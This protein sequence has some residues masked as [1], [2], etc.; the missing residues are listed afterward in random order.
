MP[1]WSPAFPPTATNNKSLGALRPSRRPEILSR[2]GRAWVVVALVAV[3]FLATSLLRTINVPW[4]EEDN[5][6]GA[7][8]AQAAANNLR[9]GLAVTAGV[10]A[11]FHVGPLPI[12]PDAYYVHHP[13]L[14]PLLVTASVAILGEKEWAVKLVPILCSIVSAIL[15][16]FLVEEAMGKRPAAF[17]VAFFVT[18]PMEL[19]YGDLVDFEPCLVT[20]MLAALLCLRHW[21]V[22]RNARWASLAALCCVGALWT[23]WPGY[24]FTAAV[25]TRLLLK[26]DKPSRRLAALLAVLALC[27]GILFLLQIRH[28]NPEGWRDLRTAISM[29]LGNGTQPG[30]SVNGPGA[31]I[32][33]GFWEWLRRIFQALDQNYLRVTWLFVLAGAVHL[34]RHRKSPRPKWIAWTALLMAVAG[35]PY[36]VILRNWSFVHDFASFFVMGSIAILG[37]MGI[38]AAWQWVEGWAGSPRIAA[39]ATA[40]LLP[41]LAW[42]GFRRAEEQRSPFLIL[43]GSVREPAHLIP[44]LGRYLATVFPA[45]TTILCNFDP[46][47]SPLSYY[48]KRAVLRNLITPAEWNF[49]MASERGNLGG[50]LWRD[51]PSTPQIMAALPAEEISAIEIDGITFAV[52]RGKPPAASKSTR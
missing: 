41:S 17:V 13:V 11:T 43:D 25:S 37:G 33:F 35:I 50:I 52:W 14:V 24:L 39:I 16:W 28:V 10:P 31:T 44:D 32:H 3:A 51:A 15:L 2:N 45:E 40:L 26:N 46:Y 42:A 48:A 4:V 38:E 20:W 1:A 7:A 6:F 8:Y 27:S 29:R 30:S 49:A 5:A 12:P 19:H 9:A 22:R 34:F 18:L 21:D 47:Y 23:D 36:L